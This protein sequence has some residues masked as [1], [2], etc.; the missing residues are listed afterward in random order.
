MK[1]LHFIFKPI[2]GHSEIITN[3]VE[4][5]LFKMKIQSILKCSTME[6]CQEL[7]STLSVCNVIVPVM[8]YHLRWGYKFW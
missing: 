2:L 8:L 4:N 3:L 7:Q 6:N 5:H 1:I